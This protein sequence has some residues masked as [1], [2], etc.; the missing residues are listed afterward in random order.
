[1][2]PSNIHEIVVIYPANIQ[3]HRLTFQNNLCCL[4]NVPGD[5]QGPRKIIGRSGRDNPKLWAELLLRQ[6]IN[7]LTDCA[8]TANCNNEFKTPFNSNFSC[9]YGIAFSC[10]GMCRCF[11]SGNFKP[12]QYSSQFPFKGFPPGCRI[13]YDAGFLHVTPPHRNANQFLHPAYIIAFFIPNEKPYGTEE[14]IPCVPITE[15]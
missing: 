3:K 6:T 7:D 11:K 10:G 9:I 15:K 8:V 4:F 2:A 13:I 12:L 5:V 14:L 1:A